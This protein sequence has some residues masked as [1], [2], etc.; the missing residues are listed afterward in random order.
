MPSFG[1]AL[2]SK[3][4]D[5]VVRFVRGFCTEKKWPRGEFNL[6]PVQF[7]EKAFPD[8]EVIIRRS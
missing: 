8:D 1:E 6:P 2:T 3:E 5:Q 4:I 7:T